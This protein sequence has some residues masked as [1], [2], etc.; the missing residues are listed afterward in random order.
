MDAQKR[1]ITRRLDSVLN[2]LQDEFQSWYEKEDFESKLNALERAGTKSSRPSKLKELYR[3]F[4]G[5]GIPY[6]KG[7]D[8]AYYREIVEQADISSNIEDR[9]L[10]A[11]YTRYSEYPSPEDYMQRMVERLS[12]EEDSWSE[13]SLRLRILKQFIK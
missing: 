8:N 3:M 11:L 12:A 6:E 13:D 5:C 4:D 10:Y 7:R 9:M 2:G 1:T